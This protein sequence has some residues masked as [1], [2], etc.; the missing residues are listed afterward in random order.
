MT[1]VPRRFAA[2]VASCA[3]LGIPLGASAQLPPPAPAQTPA[4]PPAP[5]VASA[6]GEDAQS[7]ASAHYARGVKLYE[8]DDYRAAL[9]EFTRAYA[10][11]PNWAVLY[12]LGQA[13]YQLRE[14][15]LAMTTLEKY[16][17]EGGEGVAVDRRA[18]VE[19]E[20]QELRGRVARVTLVSSVDGAD[21]ALDETPAGRTPEGEPLVVGEGRHRLTVSKPGYVATTKVVDLA[22]GDE[23]TVHVDPPAERVV[24]PAPTLAREPPSYTP[25]IV[26]GVVGVTGIAV[27]TVF[28]VLAIGDK[29][30][31]RAE[32]NPGK[33]CPASAQGDIDAFSRNGAISTVGFGVGAAGVALGAYLF[34]HERSRAEPP[35]SSSRSTRVT[36]W[37]GPGAGGV[38][39]AF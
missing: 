19:R 34:L 17:K 18:Q 2:L 3:L 23:V 14:Y 12:N 16:L 20:I 31:L 4:T 28:G 11:A 6:P 27:G 39:G 35:A 36:P 37:I 13:H 33:I 5:V 9:I 38:T 22:G 7:Q 32:C 30:S 24:A 21:V 8:E 26:V 10:L 15:A 1:A 29:S 25:A